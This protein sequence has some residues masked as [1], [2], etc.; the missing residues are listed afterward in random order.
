MRV[1]PIKTEK[2]YLA[3]LQEIERL[4]DSKPNTPNGNKLDVLAMLVQKYE[5]EHYPIDFPDA[6]TAIEYWIES[7]G[8][9]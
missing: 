9:E 1:S 3:S 8:L 7:R 4:F 6:I 5:E 2:E